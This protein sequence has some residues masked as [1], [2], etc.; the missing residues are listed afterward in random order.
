VR[1]LEFGLGGIGL[2]KKILLSLILFLI[3]HISFGAIAATTNW[4]FQENATASGVNGGGFDYG[5]ANFDATL[6]ATTAT[7][8]SPVVASSNYNFVAGDV[9][10]WIYIK[11]GT[12][13]T[14]GWYQIASVASNDAT[15]SA[16]IGQAIQV[17]A[18]GIYMTNTVAGC[19][20][21][22]SPSSGTWGLD[23][24]QSTAAY[25]TDSTLA[26][27]NGTTNPSTVTDVG[28]SFGVNTI[29]NILQITAGTNWTKGWYEVVSVSAGAATL[30]KAVGSSATLTSGTYYLGG[31]LNAGGWTTTFFTGAASTGGLNGGNNVWIKYNSSS[32][33]VGQSAEVAT[34]CTSTAICNIIGYN[35]THGDTPTGTNRPTIALGANVWE[36]GATKGASNLII[37][38]AGAYCADSGTANF[39]NDKMINSATAAG[40]AALIIS[41]QSK[42]QNNELVCQNGDGL[43]ITNGYGTIAEGNYIHDSN[44]GV[45]TN[46]TGVIADN[47][48][49]SITSDAIDLTGTSYS[50]DVFNNTI[51]GTET[52]SGTG[53]LIAN[54]ASGNKIDNN[55]FYGLT[56]GISQTTAQYY[57]NTGDYNDYYN[58]TTNYSLYYGGQH[59]FAL[60]P[61]F[62]SAGQITGTTAT[63]TGSTVTDT[64]KSFTTN[65]LAGQYIH[66]TAGTG[67]TNGVYLIV[68]NTATVITTNNAV[69]TNTTG[70]LVYYISTKHNYSITNSSLY[71]GAF[72]GTFQG[73]ASATVGYL[74]PGGVQHHSSG[75]G[76]SSNGYTY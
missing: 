15:L 55:I 32:Y 18:N 45:Y 76:S 3:P 42:V 44:V 10:N 71:A 16:A 6:S 46:Q 13:W 47:I 2:M 28:L 65:A 43:E 63:S 75:S 60:N 40:D 41:T 56:T 36:S 52:P 68:S 25:K 70:N 38:C 4:E 51:Y 48:I 26:S 69:G 61:T 17:N 62:S 22:A 5:N 20:T 24:S 34:N 27:V 8:N 67:Q 9:G 1:Q 7:G 50:A 14:P 29:G 37:T 49:E 59:D 58:N 74:D 30:D 23:Y 53:I 64:T 33:S 21:T 54:T 35:T 31:A 72:P 12:N 39:I 73:N 57:T 19:A 66:V 11:S